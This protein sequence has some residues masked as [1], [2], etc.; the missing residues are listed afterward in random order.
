MIKTSS[1]TKIF[2]D[3]K[4]GKII[5]VNDVSIEC[6]PG[7]IFGLL[8]LNG[9]G[10]TT[11]MRL[12]S[13]SLKPTSGT[14][15]VNGNDILIQPEQVKANIGFLSGDTG[16]YPRLTAEE[17]VRYFARLNGMEEQKIDER[18]KEIFDRFDMNGFKDRK[19]DKLSQ[20]MKQKVSIART[21]VQDPDVL[22]LDEPT[23][24]LDV[25]TSRNIIEF[26][27]DSKQKGK[28]VMF[29]THIMH[30]AEKLCDDIAIIH[31]GEILDVATLEEYRKKT[32]LTDLDN[33]FVK[34]I[35]E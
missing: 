11:L 18:I 3:K 16:L 27:K 30:E 24:G 29:S 2:Q 10:K 13:T 15:E 4:R 5:A 19:I 23:L 7:R 17:I 22:I 14:A 21:I 20:G 33:I 8:G 28:C 34:I 6:R 12:L 25:I 32:N 31:Q 9:A 1:L 26:I 35:G